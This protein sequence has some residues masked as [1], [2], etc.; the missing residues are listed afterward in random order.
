M[1]D[2]DFHTSGDHLPQHSEPGS[3]SLLG[4][5]S[6]DTGGFGRRGQDGMRI[7]YVGFRYVMFRVWTV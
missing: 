5:D 1:A 2:T 4:Q 6:K 7:L 3:A